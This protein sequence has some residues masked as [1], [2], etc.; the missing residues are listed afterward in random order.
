MTE[1]SSLTRAL[2]WSSSR[3]CVG[4]QAA[5]DEVDYTDPRL[6]R[7]YQHAANVVDCSND[8]LSLFV[9]ARQPGQFWNLVLTQAAS[10]LTL[11][12]SVETTVRLV[13]DEVR[14]FQALEQTVTCG[15]AA[16]RFME[17]VLD[18]E[19]V[20]Q[21][22]EGADVLAQ[23]RPLLVPAKLSEVLHRG[24]GRAGQ[25]QFTRRPA[26]EPSQDRRPVA[27]HG[28]QGLLS[29]ADRHRGRHVRGHR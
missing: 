27:A 14:A 19:P 25:R 11:Q 17:G 26:P 6:Y 18:S 23:A 20:A 29:G 8:V 21:D 9:E 22:R 5:V 24:G 16:R 3:T 2:K 28:E 10:G 13:Q 12:E 7:M 15:P 4:F 1:K